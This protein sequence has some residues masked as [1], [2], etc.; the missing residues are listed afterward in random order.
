MAKNTK[1]ITEVAKTQNKKFKLIKR[2][3]PAPYYGAAYRIIIGS[4]EHL[5]SWKQGVEQLFDEVKKVGIDDVVIKY[6][7]DV[8]QASHAKPN[9]DPEHVQEDL[10]VNINEQFEAIRKFLDMIFDPKCKQKALVVAGD[11]GIGKSHE[12]FEYLEMQSEYKLVKG[13][14]SPKALFNTL[15]RYKDGTLLFDD[16]DA[17]WEAPDALN[18]LKSA[19]ETNQKGKRIVCWNLANEDEEFEFNGQ[20]IFLSNKD[21]FKVAA[22]NK[23]IA[24][25]LT[26]VLFVQ[27]TNNPE[28]VMK[29]IEYVATKQDADEQ[30]RKVCL[31]FMRQEKY[32][33]VKKSIRMYEQ[34]S[35]ICKKYGENGFASLASETMRAGRLAA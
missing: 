29:R 22:K 34:L 27:I 19:M 15:K 2:L 9:A 1:G 8:V 4:D 14:S 35:D 33:K 6:N 7:Y 32:A 18:L 12:V 3:Y 25:T 13:Y 31:D 11:G 28:Q 10:D 26:R 5:I 17:I 16:C 23:H 30:L 20:I 24:A 21:F